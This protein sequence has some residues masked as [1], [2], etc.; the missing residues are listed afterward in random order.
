MEKKYSIGKE[1]FH[2]MF[3]SGRIIYIE[4]KGD[5]MKISVDFEAVGI[6]K[7]RVKYANLKVLN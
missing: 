4:G 6:K 1:V 3:G 7:L 5:S 2:E